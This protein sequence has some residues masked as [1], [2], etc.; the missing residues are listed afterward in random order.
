VELP[1]R[2]DGPSAHQEDLGA[3][4]YRCLTLMGT[5]YAELHTL[6]DLHDPI[7][8]CEVRSQQA[9][10]EYL[11]QCTY[12]IST[13]HVIEQALHTTAADAQPLLGGVEGCPEADPTPDDG[14]ARDEPTRDGRKG[15]PLAFEG[16]RATATMALEARRKPEG[17]DGRSPSTDAEPTEP[18]DISHAAVDPMGPMPTVE[19]KAPAEAAA[20]RAHVRR[21]TNE[22]WRHFPRER[23]RVVPRWPRSSGG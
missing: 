1:P 19:A 15:G 10:A 4:A 11:Q 7:A 13:L 23:L 9:R 18:S 5:L 8:I 22:S 21:S 17:G 2:S 6:A 3:P 20:M 16:P 12:L 14:G